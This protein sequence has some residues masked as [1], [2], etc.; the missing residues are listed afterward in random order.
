MISDKHTLTFDLTSDNTREREMKVR[1]LL[2]QNSDDS[3]G[4]EVVLKLEEQVGSTSHFTEYAR[5]TYQIRRSFSS[6]FDF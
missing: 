5:M 3:N 2:S 4:K 6:D 1:F